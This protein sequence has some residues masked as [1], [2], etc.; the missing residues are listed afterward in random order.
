[1][2]RSASPI[3]L[4]PVAHAV[5]TFVHFPLSP[6]W[7]DTFPAAIL[8]II[9]GTIS[10]ATLPGPFSRIV[11]YCFSICCRL[12]IP[13]PMIT[14]Q[15]YGSSFSI[16][17]PA[18]AHASFAAATAYWENVSIL[19]DALK[20]IRS[21]ATKSLTSA[22]IFTL[23]SVV[24]NFVIGPIPTVPFLIPFQNSSTVLPIG[25]IA[26]SPVITT[27]RFILPPLV[28]NAE[29][30]GCVRLCTNIPVGIQV[31]QTIPMSLRNQ[32]LCQQRLP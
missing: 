30:I 12:P 8:E 28:E 27:L 7:I 23:Y 5:T 16:S 15:R 17:N 22:A 20:S 10:G 26:P 24:S 6:S 21:F 11:V 25:V 18:S 2:A 29:N 9:I 31:V 3:Q 32:G 1:M 14:P 19:F 4:V 13:E